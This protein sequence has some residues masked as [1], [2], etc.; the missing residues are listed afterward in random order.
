MNQLSLRYGVFIICSGLLLLYVITPSLIP[1]FPVLVVIA[2]IG[3]TAKSTI[4]GFRLKNA[5]LN[6]VHIIENQ[7]KSEI[8]QKVKV[9]SKNQYEKINKLAL[10]EKICSE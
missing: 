3:L 6:Q 7:I 5:L 10:I 8:V 1:W 2:F 9:I 4:D